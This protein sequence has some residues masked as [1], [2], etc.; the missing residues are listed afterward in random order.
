MR[1]RLR[2][3]LQLTKTMLTIFIVFLVT[4][5]PAV[6]SNVLESKLPFPILHLVASILSWTSAVINPLVY[7]L[8]HHQYKEVFKEFKTWFNGE[9]E[10]F[11]SHCVLASHPLFHFVDSYN[12]KCWQCAG[13]EGISLQVN[14]TP[15]VRKEYILIQAK[16]SAFSPLP[17][18]S[19]KRRRG[20]IGNSQHW[21]L[22]HC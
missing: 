9:T 20:K 10:G 5:L 13:S 14:W 6:V 7:S 15:I 8:L 22:N 17:L 11:S 12:W 16:P 18:C 1:M 3:D 2:E 21:H 19:C 4:F